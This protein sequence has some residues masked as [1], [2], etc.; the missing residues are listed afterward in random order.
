MIQIGTHMKIEF[1]TTLSDLKKCN[2]E[3]EVCYAV[4]T[5]WW[6][7]I[8]DHPGYK[9]NDIPVD[10]RGSV[11]MMAPLG[12]FIQGAEKNPDYYGKYGL[13]AFM[14]AY[15]GNLLTDDGK[16]TSLET[17]EEYEELLNEQDGSE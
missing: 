5:C 6:C 11:L 15:H 4:R 17:W 7:L 9:I 13:K 1:K 14:A 16:P 12:R 8:Q 2:P 10:P 3:H